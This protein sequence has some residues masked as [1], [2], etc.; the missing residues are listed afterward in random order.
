MATPTQRYGTLRLGDLVAG[1]VSAVESRTISHC[2]GL[3]GSGLPP[4]RGHYPQKT[5]SLL[6]DGILDPSD[7]SHQEFMGFQRT[8]QCYP[9]CIIRVCPL[10]PGTEEGGGRVDKNKEKRLV[11]GTCRWNEAPGFI[12]GT[13]EHRKGGSEKDKEGE[14]EGRI[15]GN[16]QQAP[17]TQSMLLYACSPTCSPI[18][19]PALLKSRL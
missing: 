10:N 16:S 6:L 13:T 8:G 11:G 7:A 17:P 4:L 1:Q 14:K 15:P 9:L 19:L 18:F 2:V 12:P 5:P 3:S